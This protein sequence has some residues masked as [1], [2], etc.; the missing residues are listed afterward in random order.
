MTIY[1]G[2][3]GYSYKEWKGN[4]YPEK[5]PANEMLSHYAEKLPAVE[6]NNTFYR[7]PRA[8]VLETWASQVPPAFRF[9]LKASRRITHIRRL[10]DATDETRYLLEATATLGQLLGV[11]FFQ[12]P[13]NLAADVERLRDF[14]AL[15]PEGTP[16]AFEFRHASWFDDSV[17]EALRAHNAALCL[18]DTDDDLD[19]PLV[20]TAS[21]GYLRLRRAS[22]PD[23][24]LE[25]WLDWIRSQDWS[26]AYVFFKHEEAGA[27]PEMA[28]RFLRLAG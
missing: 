28:A 19:V 7:L 21:W 23:G 15:L 24:E 14:L 26:D 6:V 10:K 12:L 17:Y 11:V 2:T 25:K 27:G 16:A 4:F 5:I 9:S 8:S 1:A 18:A 20:S 22:Y 3:S 13:P